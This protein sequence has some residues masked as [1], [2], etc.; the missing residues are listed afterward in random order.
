MFTN[1][2]YN[3]TKAQGD[4]YA[5]I[6]FQIFN[7]WRKYIH[8]AL[9]AGFRYPTSSSVDAARFTDAPGYHFDVSAAKT[10]IR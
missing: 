9:R 10:F 2:G 1:S 3:D 7:K 4:I 8:L 6:N 5:N